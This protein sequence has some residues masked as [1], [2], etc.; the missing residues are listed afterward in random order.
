MSKEAEVGEL[1][2][3]QT[4]QVASGQMP[5]AIA[6]ATGACPRTVRK[7]VDRSAKDWRDCRIAPLV[8]IGCT[9]RHRR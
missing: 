7:W 6:E 5:E 4:R 1:L 8:R 9:D 3:L 2:K